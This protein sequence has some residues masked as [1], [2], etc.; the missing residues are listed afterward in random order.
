ML[1]LFAEASG[2]TVLHEQEDYLDNTASWAWQQLSIG[3]LATVD[4]WAEV[5]VENLAGVPV[6]FDDLEIQTGAAPA[7]IVVQETHYDPWGLEL[8]GIGYVADPAKESKFTYNGKEKQ[9][10]F[11]LGWL[12]Y[13]ARQVD[14]ALGRMWAVDPHSHRYA[15]TSPYAYVGNNPISRIDPDGKDWVDQASDDEAKRIDKEYVK[16]QKSL[17]REDKKL[18]KQEAKARTKKQDDKVREITQKRVDLGL[19]MGQVS[20]ARRELEL[21]GNDRD[22]HFRLDPT[23]TGATGH[24]EHDAQGVIVVKYNKESIGLAAHELKHGYQVMTGK[25]RPVGNDPK[26]FEFV[27]GM[28][29]IRSEVEAYQRQYA[30]GTMPPSKNTHSGTAGGADYTPSSFM[31]VTGT[32]IRGLYTTSTDSNGNVILHFPYQFH[33]GRD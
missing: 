20:A 6:W 15:N 33:L 12:D 8:A 19:K 7:P 27:N 30:F 5:Y 28:T 3:K 10:Q 23:A 32:Y 31:N 4:C 14:P 16:T 11:G 17:D 1:R 18:A 2:G 29:P 22:T 26:I 13:H 24:I 25:L 9:D 21:M